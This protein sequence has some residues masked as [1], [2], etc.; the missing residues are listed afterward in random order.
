MTVKSYYDAYWSEDGFLPAN[1]LVEPFRGIID[2]RVTTSTDCLDVGCGDGRT[3]LW[4]A[5]RAR[6]YVGVDVSESAVRAARLRGMD[7]RL[8][9]DA[10]LL[11][12]PD[13]SFDVA[14]CIEVLEHLFD[15]EGAAA[16]IRRVLRPGGTLVVSVPNCAFWRRRVD[17][18]TGRWNP[19]GD[20][21]SVEKPWRDPHIRFFTRAALHRMLLCAGYSDAVV[22]GHA[23]GFVHSMPGLPAATRTSGTSVLYRSA[24]RRLPSLLGLRLHA[25]ATR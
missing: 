15:P 20:L 21:E 6:S 13:R 18:L 17:L 11:P 12:F 24:E 19:F 9:A 25:L 14:L 16:E 3:G 22:S 10:A 7:A 1:P 4:L 8:V 23:G 2:E 5:R